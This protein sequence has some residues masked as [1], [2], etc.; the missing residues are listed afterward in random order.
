MLDLNLKD[1]IIKILL[2]IIRDAFYCL[3]IALIILGIIEV[4]KP[5][6]FLNHLNLSWYLAI[7]ILL[8]AVYILF[9]PVR[10]N[11]MKKMKLLDYSTV[12]LLS[13]IFGIG[14]IYLL[15]GIG[16]LNILIGICTIFICYLFITLSFKENI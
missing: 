16:P 11:E 12:I 3:F 9:S 15:R 7:T 2:V 6:F 10:K 1:K 14:I 8:G 5:G 4:F 13:I